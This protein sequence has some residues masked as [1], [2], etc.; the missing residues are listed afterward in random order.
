[1]TAEQGSVLLLHVSAEEVPPDGFWQPLTG[2]IE[3]TETAVQ[4]AVRE[5][6][7]ETGQFVAE[8]E[9]RFVADG[10]RV[11]V[12]EDFEVV[13]SLFVVRLPAQVVTVDPSEHDGFR[14]VSP[15]EVSGL[16]H[17]E[18]NRETWEQVRQL[19]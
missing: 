7:E 1:M 12:A 5:V 16:L 15:A 8:E 9:F 13:K 10:I 19:L 18:S 6:R 11:R 3:P 14:W 2:G 4:A 17:W